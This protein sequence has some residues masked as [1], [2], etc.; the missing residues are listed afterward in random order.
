MLAA[1]GLLTQELLQNPVGIDG[2]AIR[3]LD[4]LDD[5]FPEFGEVSLCLRRHMYMY[6]VFFCLYMAY[7]LCRVDLTVPSKRIQ[8][9]KRPLLFMYTRCS[10]CCAPLSRAGAL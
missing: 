8:L 2:P 7:A 9:I 6:N 10:F 4:L 5:K 3:H 1:V